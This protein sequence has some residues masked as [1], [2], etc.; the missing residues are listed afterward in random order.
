MTKKQAAEYLN[1][2]ESTIDNLESVGMLEPRRLYLKPG[3]KRALVR[4]KQKDLDALFEKRERG[5]PRQV[6]ITQ[7]S[8]ERDSAFDFR[9]LKPCP[10]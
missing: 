9:Q 7:P 5:G 8:L 10:G 4:Y 6:E 3:A 1:A 2:C